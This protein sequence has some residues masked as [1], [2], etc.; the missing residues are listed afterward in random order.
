MEQMEGGG[1]LT[2][3]ATQLADTSIEEAYGQ[4]LE[5]LDELFEGGND[6]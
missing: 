2:N 4:L 5:I 3:A 1:H 6:E